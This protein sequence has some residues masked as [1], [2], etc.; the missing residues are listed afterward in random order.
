MSGL[1]FKSSTSSSVRWMASGSVI[2]LFLAK[3]NFLREAHLHKPSLT[4]SRL[5]SAAEK[6]SRLE[7]L[8]MPAGIPSKSSWLSQTY[9]F[10]SFVSLQSPLGRVWI[11]FLERIKVFQ[12][13]PLLNQGRNFIDLIGSEV[14]SLQPWKSQDTLGNLSQLVLT[15]IDICQMNKR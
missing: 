7:S 14:E 5:L 6:T 4:I 12:H 2:N 9:N 15:E 8:P 3:I 11:L 13:G 10:R 1:P